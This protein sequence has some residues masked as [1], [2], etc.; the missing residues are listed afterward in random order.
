MTPFA[1]EDLQLGYLDE[2]FRENPP[3][4]SYIVKGGESKIVPQA[5]ILYSIE[6]V[7]VTLI[8]ISRIPNE[9]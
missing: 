9:H 8:Q 5:E 2:G 6:R 1:R 4:G 7:G 3:A